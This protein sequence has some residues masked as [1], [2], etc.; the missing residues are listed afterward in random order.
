ME[1]YNIVIQNKIGG[2][3]KSAAKAKL[4]AKS[5]ISRQKETKS[6][7]SKLKSYA[8]AGMSLSSSKSNLPKFIKK[9][10]GISAGAMVVETAI[11]M[12]DYGLTLYNANTGNNRY[13]HNARTVLNTMATLGLNYAFGAIKNELITKRIVSRQNYGLDYGRELYSINVEGTK[14]KRI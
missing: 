3:S 5:S 7:T 8:N 1:D 6:I 12:A 13:T 10:I 11:K 2:G 9:N 4:S 14:H